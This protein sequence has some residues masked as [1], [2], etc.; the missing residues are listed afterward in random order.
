MTST[1]EC[2][3]CS[4]AA[5]NAEASIV[6]QDDQVLAF[7]DPRQFHPGHVLVIPR[8]HTPD[9]CSLDT[10]DAGPLM[11]IVAAMSKAVDKAFPSDGLS[12]WI[13]TGPGA[14]QE[15]PHLHVHVHPRM[16]RDEMLR[17]YPSGAE[18][19]IVRPPKEMAIPRCRTCRRGGPN[20]QQVIFSDP[21]HT[22]DA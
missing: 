20:S 1:S 16:L 14:Y 3:F 10:V 13:S 9:I 17:P 12:I 6:Y 19:S 2:V 18:R 21:T 7:M 11:T 22:E 5:G 15:V 8:A 4:I